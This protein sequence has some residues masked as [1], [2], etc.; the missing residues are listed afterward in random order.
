MED[1]H[2]LKKLVRDQNSGS[3]FQTDTHLKVKELKRGGSTNRIQN[4]KLEKSVC[5]L[6]QDLAKPIICYQVDSI[7]LAREWF[8]KH[9]PICVW[10]RGM[11]RLGE[12]GKKWAWQSWKA[13]TATPWPDPSVCPG[14]PRVSSSKP[15]V[16]FGTVTAHRIG[17]NYEEDWCRSDR[18]ASWYLELL[19]PK[20]LQVI[21]L[22]KSVVEKV[23]FSIL[24]NFS[25]P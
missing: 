5:L 13:A 7:W 22:K 1:K 12:V 18:E 8:C 17:K 6:V 4:G 19:I 11:T 24:T 3:N 16:A 25:L 14:R 10:G 15:N 20:L 2:L 23:Q 21:K 9:Q